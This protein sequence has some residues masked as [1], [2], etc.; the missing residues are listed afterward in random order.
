M[1]CPS[2]PLRGVI[3]QK[4]PISYIRAIFYFLYFCLGLYLQQY[5]L[6]F[7]ITEFATKTCILWTAS[8]PRGRSSRVGRKAGDIGFQCHELPPSSSTKERPLF[9]KVEPLYPPI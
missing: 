5:F 6:L 8:S 7:R 4:L 2:H 1:P 9:T 3:I